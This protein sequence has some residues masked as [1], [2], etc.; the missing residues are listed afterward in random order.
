MRTSHDGRVFELKSGLLRSERAAWKCIKH[1]CEKLG[2]DGPPL[3]I[4]IDAWIETALDIR[5]GVSDLTHLG[6]DVLGAAFVR[7]RE[8]LV[9]DRVLENNGRFRFTCAHELGHV[10]LHQRH[11]AAFHETHELPHLEST[12][13]EKEADRFAAAILMPLQLMEQALF[14]I[15]REEELDAEHCLSEMMMPTVPSEWLWRA[16]FLPKITQRFGVSKTAAV[17][18]CGD[19]RLITHPT[20]SLLP[21][22]FRDRLL[23]RP[24]EID[25]Q[26]MRVINGRPAMISQSTK[27]T[28]SA[29]G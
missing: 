28:A 1:C 2:L 26:F 22:R 18:R 23:E 15:C 7:D 11:A 19:M 25:L 20:R 24:M 4:P 9:S 29:G 13:L 21:L 10:L 12:H 6:D 27:R 17:I 5:F 8:I 3:P 16:I 14:S